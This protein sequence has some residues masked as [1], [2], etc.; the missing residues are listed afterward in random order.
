MKTVEQS[1]ELIAMTPDML[2]VI[3]MAGRTC[4]KSEDKM[5][6]VDGHKVVYG[7][8]E[9]CHERSKKFVRGLIKRKHESVLEHASATVRLITDRGMTHEIVRHRLAS[10]SQ[11]STRFCNYGHANEITV[12]EPDLPE[13]QVT[14]WLSA[15]N[16]C[17]KVYL[18]MVEDGVKPE[19]ARSVLPTCLKTEIVVTANMRQ[20]RHM[21]ALRLGD[22]A[23][24]AHPQIKE[25][26]AM[27]LCEFEDVGLD[28]LFED[29]V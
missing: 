11:E 25:L 24:K 20:W 4:Y 1:A 17:E 13:D 19:W 10:Y 16:L 15:V 5:E 6:C 21:M 22:A 14:R 3:E 28:V 9:T 27:I 23:G 7:L 18:E 29:F 12:I 8:C 26:F 2:H